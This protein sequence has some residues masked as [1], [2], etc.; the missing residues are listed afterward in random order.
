MYVCVRLSSEIWISQIMIDQDFIY[1]FSFIRESVYDL[2]HSV[3]YSTAGSSAR[4]IPDGFNFL[5]IL[6]FLR[7]RVWLSCHYSLNFEL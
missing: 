5:F 6:L 3:H 4:T 2:V 1:F 7:L